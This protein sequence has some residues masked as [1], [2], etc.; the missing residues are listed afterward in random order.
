MAASLKPIPFL[1]ATPPLPEAAR[2]TVLFDSEHAVP[3]NGEVVT[4]RHFGPA[5]TAGDTLVFFEQARVVHVGD[6][7]LGGGGRAVASPIS[8]GTFEGLLRALDRLLELAPADAIVVGGHGK[9]GETWSVAD[10]AR[11][12]AILRSAI[13]GVARA[14]AAGESLE[15]FLS[16]AVVP[17]WSAWGDRE[18]AEA[19]LQAIWNAEDG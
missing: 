16:T 8:G 15:S 6:V 4:L 2:P 17:G 5:H 3:I 11:Y 9:L 1:P 10:V 14:R 7:F 13:D 18:G 19:L 12:R